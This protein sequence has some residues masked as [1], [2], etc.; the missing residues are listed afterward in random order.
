MNLAFLLINKMLAVVQEMKLAMHV[1][2]DISKTYKLVQTLV[3]VAQYAKA[4][5]ILKVMTTTLIAY[6]ATITKF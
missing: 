1:Q 4:V 5:S 6:H 3:P 2:Q